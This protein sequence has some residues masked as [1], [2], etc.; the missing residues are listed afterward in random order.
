MVPAS[1]PADRDWAKHKETNQSIIDDLFRGQFRSLVLCAECQNSMET[2]SDT[3]IMLSLPLL[4]SENLTLDC[5]LE[6]FQRPEK[7][8]PGNEAKCS[9]CNMASR[10]TKTLNVWRLPDFLIISLTRFTANREK[11]E[12]AVKFPLENLDLSEFDHR[13]PRRKRVYDLVAVCNHTG[14]LA[15]GHYTAYCKV[16]NTWYEL[17]DDKVNRIQD[18][19][20]CSPAA[21]LL[22]YALRADTSAT[23]K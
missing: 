23:A 16:A 15:S 3:F 20:V 14:T 13:T 4:S 12:N 7:L 8:T 5:C 2:F 22:F 6:D 19:T 1:T 11:I 10:A 9:K 18:T 17:N 21:Y